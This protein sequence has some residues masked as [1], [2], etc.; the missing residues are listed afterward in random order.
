[1]VQ[2]RISTTIDSQIKT[3][4]QEKTDRDFNDLLEEKCREVLEHQSD[5]GET[6]L[7]YTFDWRPFTPQQ[8]E[9]A[10]FV[11]A[12]CSDPK[13]KEDLVKQANRRG[14]YSTKEYV[15]NALE[16]LASSD[17]PIVK[18]G[19]GSSSK[20]QSG[21]V[22]CEGHLMKVSTLLEDDEPGLK[23]G[24]CPTCGKVFEGLVR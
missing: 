6:A 14:I 7:T 18:E 13:T 17:L 4:I 2:S 11:M 8:K 21:K 16:R 1:M 22:Q 15:K 19:E 10:K 24:Q 23:L 9:L 12:N 20:F 3:K 5:E